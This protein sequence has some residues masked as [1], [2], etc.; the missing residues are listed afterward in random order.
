MGQDKSQLQ[1]PPISE[2]HADSDWQ[3]VFDTGHEQQ[4]YSVAQPA[5]ELPFEVPSAPLATADM[6]YGRGLITTY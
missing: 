5:L 3:H 1:D 2:D 6:D 4:T